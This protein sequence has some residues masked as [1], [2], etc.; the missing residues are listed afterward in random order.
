M[1]KKILCASYHTLR[2]L[3]PAHLFAFNQGTDVNSTCGKVVCQTIDFSPWIFR[4]GAP[5]PIL[6]P[7]CAGCRRGVHDEGCGVHMESTYMLSQ[8]GVGSSILGTDN[9]PQQLLPRPFYSALLLLLW[10][11]L[12]LC[13]YYCCCSRF[14]IFYFQ[15]P[16]AQDTVQSRCTTSSAGSTSSTTAAATAANTK[17]ANAAADA[18]FFLP[19]INALQL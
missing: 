8:S 11:L 18:D 12:L 19:T 15:T 16:P 1:W 14:P 10:R 13:F 5:T 17:F 6:Q 2:S 4:P 9:A 7:L 3:G